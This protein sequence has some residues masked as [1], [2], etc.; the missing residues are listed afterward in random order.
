MEAH[1]NDWLRFTPYGIVRRTL[2]G[3]GEDAGLSVQA[4]KY[5]YC[6]PRENQVPWTAV[7]VGF[8]SFVP[9][10]VMM[11]YAEEADKPTETVYGYVPIEIVVDEINAHGGVDE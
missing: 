1:M 3:I 6:S 4:G 2:T 5:L 9:S 10:A 7:E 8:L 11:E